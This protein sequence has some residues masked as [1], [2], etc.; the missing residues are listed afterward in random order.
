LTFDNKE[1]KLVEQGSIPHES[2]LDLEP[3]DEE[4]SQNDEDEE[5]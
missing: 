5:V 1:K 2:E 3:S 4:N